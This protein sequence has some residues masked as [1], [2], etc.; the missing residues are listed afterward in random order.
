MFSVNEGES[1]RGRII[2]GKNYSLEG[3]WYC[4]VM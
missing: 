4:R 2:Y 1:P 3:G